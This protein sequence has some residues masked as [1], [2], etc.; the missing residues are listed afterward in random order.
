VTITESTFVLVDTESTDREPEHAELLEV[1]ARR[2]DGSLS[3]VDRFESLVRPTRP[4]PPAASA[5]HHIVDADVAGAPERDQVESE[6]LDYLLP[7][8]PI[9]TA[10]NAP[11]DRAMLGDRFSS[12][13]WL[14]TERMAHHLCPDAPEYKNATLYYWMGG[15]K[16]TTALHR[17]DADLDITAFNFS[18]LLAAYR[19]RAAEICAGDAARL[20]K[21]EDVDTMLAFFARPYVMKTM[22]F[23]KHRRQPM[24]QVPTSYLRWALGGGMEDLDGDLRFN[25]ERQLQLRDGGLERAS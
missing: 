10:H 21:S 25:L 23:G 7:G 13:R 18:V 16:I 6:L 19:A 2:L 24:E 15:A 17:A 14:C 9:L 4:I 11:F 22:P 3:L 1:A 5:V 12:F 8:S 20:A